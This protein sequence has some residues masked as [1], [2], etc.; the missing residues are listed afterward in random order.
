MD[1]N[2]VNE[3][4]EKRFL[5]F[6]SQL[7]PDLWQMLSDSTESHFQFMGEFHWFLNLLLVLCHVLLSLSEGSQCFFP[8]PLK[9]SSNQTIVGVDSAELS[10]GELSF[11]VEP[12]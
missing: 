10:L 4:P 11:I 7:L 8:S 5:V 12:L 6:S 3:T 2:L 9:F 1:H